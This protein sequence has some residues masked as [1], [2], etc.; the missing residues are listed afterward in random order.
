MREIVIIDAIVRFTF[1]RYGMK[2]NLHG[3]MTGTKH[4][5]TCTKSHLNLCSFYKI[6]HTTDKSVNNLAKF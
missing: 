1:P 2:V 5:H 4:K 3:L 6:R